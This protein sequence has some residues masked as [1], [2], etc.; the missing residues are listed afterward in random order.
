LENLIKKLQ[1]I[2]FGR[3]SVGVEDETQHNVMRMKERCDRYL[4][5]YFAHPS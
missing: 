1:E 2:I 3:K 4:A 5:G